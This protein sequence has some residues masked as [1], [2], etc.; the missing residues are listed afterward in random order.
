MITDE[1]VFAAAEAGR[2]EMQAWT[3][4]P[5]P[6]IG[7]TGVIL[8]DAH[9]KREIPVGEDTLPVDATYTEYRCE[10][11]QQASELITA[12]AWRAG[13]IAAMSLRK[14]EETVQ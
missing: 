2:A 12:M 9:R 14:P 1:M 8:H 10:S 13:L 6:I 4:V 11:R 5:S 3:V 7:S